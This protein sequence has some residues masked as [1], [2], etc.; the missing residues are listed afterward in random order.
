MPCPLQ[1]D[2]AVDAAPAAVFGN[3]DAVA[4]KDQGASPCGGLSAAPAAGADLDYAA[5]IGRRIDASPSPFHVVAEAVAQIR[6]AGGRVARSSSQA[7]SPGLWYSESGGSLTAWC[8]GEAHRANSGLRIVGAHTD[9][10]NLRLKPLP[11]RGAAGFRQLGV[12]VYGSPLLNSWLDRDLGVA[13][14]LALRGADGAPRGVLVRVDEPLLRV[15]QLAVHLD[16]GV[17]DKGLVLNPQRHL[18]PIW[19]L[20]R[21]DA[22]GFVSVVAA[23]AG[24]GSADVIGHDLMAFDLAGA[25]LAGDGRA[26]L[27]SARI[28][29][30]VSCFASVDALTAAARALAAGSG[31]ATGGSRIPMVCLFDHE[32]VGSVSAHGAA[33][34]RLQRLLEFVAAGFGADADDVASSRGDSLMLSADGAH[35]THPNYPERHDPDHPVLLNGGPVLKTNASQRYATDALSGAA[36]RLACERAGVAMQHFVS[37]GDISCGTTI[38]PIAAARLGLG[39][40]DAGCAQL[41]MHSAREVCGSADIGWFAAALK[42]FLLG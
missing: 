38:G 28:D 16:R 37:R 31:A 21:S 42:E 20:E 22:A 24:V 13:G 12:E 36:F 9:S 32:E 5:R 17:N 8:I 35:A 29:N 40:V 4:D 6:A 33:S 18:S 30:L 1:A 15:P 11:D 39:V 27:S 41:A 25:R 14:R 3:D 7:A 19:G 2:P 34:G 23:A 26:M 10:P